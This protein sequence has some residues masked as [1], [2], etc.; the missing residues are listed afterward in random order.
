VGEIVEAT[1]VEQVEQVR[2]LFVE[3]RA[4]LAV[5][6][7]FH[8]F[9]EEIASL[10]GVYAPPAGKLLLANVVG[11]PVGCIGL[12]PFPSEGGCEMKRLYVRPPFRG[13]KLGR[14]LAERIIHEARR[15]GYSSM[16]LDSH[17]PSM[18]A[19]IKMYRKLGFREVSPDPVDPV[20]GLIYMELSL[21]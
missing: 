10:P 14:K 4:E 2:T 6:P 11:Q 1:S 13:D 15:L 9:D 21:A 18:E 20:P 19:A 12:R 5:E 7:C 17:P 8:S 3:Y 16:R